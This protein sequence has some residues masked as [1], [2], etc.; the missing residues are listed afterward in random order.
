[1]NQPHASIVIPTYNRGHRLKRC[2][3]S[4]PWRTERSLE[5]ILV[6]DGS[7]DMT[8]DLVTNYTNLG[9][10]IKAIRFNVNRGVGAARQAGVAHA[11]APLIL[12]LDSDDEWLPSAFETFLTAMNEPDRPEVVQAQFLNR[13]ETDLAWPSWIPTQMRDTPVHV[14]GFGSMAVTRETL[15]KIPIKESLRVGED[16]E[17]VLRAKGLGVRFNHVKKVALVRWIGQD[18]L[19]HRRDEIDAALRSILLAHARTHTKTIQ[20]RID[21]D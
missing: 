8:Q 9:A 10:P 12:W 6:D 15:L 7:T 17:W 16:L 1:M 18:N 3:D 5:I 19:C 4:I 2:L 20:N 13:L 14:P 21:S 11:T